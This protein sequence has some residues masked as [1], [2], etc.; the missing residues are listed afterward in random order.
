MRV[1]GYGFR[2]W[3][4]PTHRRKHSRKRVGPYL[5]EFGHRETAVRKRDKVNCFRAAGLLGAREAASVPD[6]ARKRVG[7][8]AGERVGQ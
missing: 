5:D 6:I 2:V 3:S 4:E 7:Q 8:W 1:K